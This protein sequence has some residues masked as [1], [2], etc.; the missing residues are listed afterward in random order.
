MWNDGRYVAEAGC[1][2]VWETYDI[3][4]MLTTPYVDIRRVAKHTKHLIIL[5][6]YMD[7]P[8][9][10]RG[11]TDV[12]PE[13]L[14]AAGADVA[15][16]QHVN[17]ETDNYNSRGTIRSTALCGIF[18]ARQATLIEETGYE[19]SLFALIHPGGAVGERLN[20]PKI[21]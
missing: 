12:L 7:T 8:R 18:H 1:G 21:S 16:K 3:D 14:K 19:E 6:P 10:G 2:A 11:M 9:P 20:R 5:A 13:N 15:L 4:V 17:R